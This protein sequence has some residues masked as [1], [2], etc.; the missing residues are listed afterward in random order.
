MQQ[1][2]PKNL[3]IPKRRKI[4]PVSNLFAKK[5]NFPSCFFE[6]VIK[7]SPQRVMS[8]N[9]VTQKTRKLPIPEEMS[10]STPE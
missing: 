3:P 7:L 5:T 6:E 9:T 4:R 2:D 8:A 1:Q 10:D